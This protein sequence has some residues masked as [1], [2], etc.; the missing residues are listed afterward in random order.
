[1]TSGAG[2]APPAAEQAWTLRTNTNNMARWKQPPG[3]AA[4]LMGERPSS[5]YGP[6][7]YPAG[8]QICSAAPSRILPHRRLR[9]IQPRRNPV[10][11]SRETERWTL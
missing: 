4:R 3:E 11:Q 6:E 1:M 9:P 2:G 7:G 10:E 5:P 8:V